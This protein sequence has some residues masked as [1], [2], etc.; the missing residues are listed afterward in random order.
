MNFMRIS[1]PVLGNLP[2]QHDQRKIPSIDEI[3]IIYD[4]IYDHIYIR[5]NIYI[6]RYQ[7][8]IVYTTYIPGS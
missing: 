8:H 3:D 5:I 7:I 4:L 6:D 1:P 2:N